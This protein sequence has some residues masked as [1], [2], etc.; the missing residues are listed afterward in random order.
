MKPIKMLIILT[1][2][3][4]FIAFSACAEECE[5]AYQYTNNGES[6]HTAACSLCGA[7]RSDAHNLSSSH[8]PANCISPAVTTYSCTLCSYVYTYTEGE[9]ASGHA[10]G[11]YVIIRAATCRESGLK[12]RTC[13][14]CG[15]AESVEEAQLEHKYGEWSQYDEKWHIRYCKVCSWAYKGSHR[16]GD[17]EITVQPTD[18]QLGLIKYTCRVCKDE[19]KNI[20]RKDGTIY[21]LDPVDVLGNGADYLLAASRAADETALSEVGFASGGVIDIRYAADASASVYASAKTGNYAGIAVENGR[22]SLDVL[23]Q[24]DYDTLRIEFLKLSKNS[25]AQIRI[26]NATGALEIENLGGKRVVIAQHKENDGSILTLLMRFTDKRDSF[27]CEARLYKSSA[28]PV[29]IA[30]KNSEYTFTL[31]EEARQIASFTFKYVRS[32]G[33]ITVTPKNHENSYNGVTIEILEGTT[34]LRSAS[35]KKT[36]ESY[37]KLSSNDSAWRLR[38][39]YPG[40]YSIETPLFKKDGGYLASPVRYLMDAAALN[41]LSAIDPTPAEDIQESE[42]ALPEA[43]AETA[44]PASTEPPA[45]HDNDVSEAKLM[46]GDTI[47][48]SSTDKKN[49]ACKG[50]A[51]VIISFDN[52]RF[53]V[54]VTGDMGGWTIS[55]VTLTQQGASSGFRILNANAIPA[56]FSLENASGTV[57]IRAQM[58]NES[59]K[60]QEVILG[61]FSLQQ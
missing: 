32:S 23:P 2:L 18:S 1:V 36:A 35:N 39:T 30:Y 43:P 33:K 42:L 16:L 25:S 24:K 58:K 40:G 54:D 22:A 21:A 11:E 48:L 34:V 61:T 8:K 5:H 12:T 27:E 3:A 59:G 29:L 50:Y 44:S 45:Q 10:F 52:M 17:G 37:V 20:L 14:D 13:P 49:F 60:T 38:A 46:T 55:S 51:A 53:S 28:S 4:L 31:P 56:Q 7:T 47:A 41:E 9:K 6:G 19:F 57:T 15:H 26:F